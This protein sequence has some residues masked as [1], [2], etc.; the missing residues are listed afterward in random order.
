MY[1]F[2][3][4]FLLACVVGCR[5]ERP[6][7][8]LS[9]LPPINKVEQAEPA[10]AIGGLSGELRLDPKV[11]A[12][13]A[14]GDVIF[15]VARGPASGSAAGPIVAVKK[16]SVDR[17]PISFSLSDEDAMVMGTELRGTVVVS[18]R[19]DKD[20]NATSKSPGDVVGSAPPTTVPASRVVVTLDQVL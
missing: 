12:H 20:G 8:P 14:S 18:A 7:P 11:K 16:L 9:G 10:Q 17:F 19:V 1:L 4:A 15:I 3:T 13:V 2:R 5:S 6:A